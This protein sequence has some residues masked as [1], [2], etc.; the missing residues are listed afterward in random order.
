MPLKEIMQF[1]DREE[2]SSTFVKYK[3]EKFLIASWD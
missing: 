2:Q 3:S 1:C